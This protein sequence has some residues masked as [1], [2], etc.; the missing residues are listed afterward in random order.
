MKKILS[1]I[2]T[3]LVFC[4]LVYSAFPVSAITITTQEAAAGVDSYTSLAPYTEF[5]NKLAEGAFYIPGL[6]STASYDKNLKFYRSSE[7]MIPQAMCTVGHYTLI[8]AYDE[9]EDAKS[10]IYVLDYNKR[11]VKTL[12]LPDS[13]HVGGIAYDS[14]NDLILVTKA[15][16]KCVGV[17]SIADFNK[18]MSFSSD[19]IKIEYT[20]SKSTSDVEIPNTSGVTYKNGKVYMS[21]FDTGN[22]SVAYCYTPYYN[23]VTKSY[24]LS[25]NY[26]FNLPNYTQGITITNYKGKTRLFVS[27]SYGRNESK[28]VYCS[29]LYSYVF[30]ELTGAKT[31]D[32]VLACPPMLQQTFVSAGKLYCLFESASNTYK[33]DNS[34][35][36]DM[37]LPIKLSKICDEKNGSSI[38]IIATDVPGGK[39]VDIVTDIPNASIYY[40]T[41]VPYI[42]NKKVTNGYSYKQSY[43]KTA[44]SM[45][46]AVAVVEGRI[47]AVDSMYIQVDR[48]KAVKGFKVSAYSKKA[49]NLKWTQNEDASGY[50]IYRSTKKGSN[51]KLIATLSSSKKSY[52]DTKVKSNKKYYYKIKAYS[53]GSLD[54]SYSGVVSVKTKKS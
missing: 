30:D 47:V 26:K 37:V 4:T 12:I 18:Y 41:G 3:L 32:N 24:S 36:V 2:S 52:K 8:T 48:A 43:L 27:V 50:Y 23:S 25:F 35:P 7:T 16:D 15:S 31:L 49:V 5:N 34:N 53:N 46:Y 22:N 44:S 54:S 29:Y 11:L 39:S 17:I 28:N 13:Y 40:S 42:K 6:N 20:V 38:N 9:T 10:V 19:F 45:V 14:L 33:A 1:V 21:C 51:Y